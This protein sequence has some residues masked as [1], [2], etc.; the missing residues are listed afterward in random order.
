MIQRR[1]ILLLIPHLG[2]GGAE[3]VAALLARGLNRD[4][5][6]V[7]VGLVTETETAARELPAWVTV[8][9]LG[10][11]RVR[12][13]GLA[14][15]RLVW[16]LRP[17]VVLSGMAHLNKLVLLLRPFFPRNARVLVR[18][19]G[20]VEGDGGPGFWKL[21]PRADAIICQTLAMA[22]EIA[23]V[24]GGERAMRV[25]PNPVDVD[26]VRLQARQ[27]A[28]R[29][30]GPG[31]HML[32]VG[33]L[34]EEKGFDLLLQA[35]A[36]VRSDFPQADLAILGEGRERPALEM[37]AWVLGLGS[38]VRMPGY[39]ACPAEWYPGASIFALSSRHEGL[40]NALLEAA[41]GGLPIVSTRA[42][43]GLVG[44]IE[45]QA[46]VWLTR[47]TSAAAITEGLQHA[48]ET[49]QNHPRFPHAWVEPFRMD[50]A[51]AQYEAL[52][53]EQFSGAAR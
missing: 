31:P 25:L 29:W 16:K 46:G 41:A 30:T 45:G 23:A 33:R 39:V 28:N 15:V 3:R 42:S 50:A 49:A 19:N 21:Y 48:I 40:P 44:L 6:D 17:D 20:R 4:R 10:A 36:R 26:Q 53:E 27:A 12:R 47:E 35:F 7:H 13:A 2:G 1:I 32:A 52:I 34:S 37:L 11:R 22:T 24:A 14:V 9:A 18:Q 5:Y 51:L 38:S 43:A 8:H